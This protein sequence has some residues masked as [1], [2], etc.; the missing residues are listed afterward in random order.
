MKTSVISVLLKSNKDPTQPSSYCPLSLINTHVK[1][2]TKAIAIRLETVIATLIHP[3]QTGHI[4]KRHDS[5]N[6]QRSFNV[7]N[8]ALQTPT[9]TIIVSLDAEKAFDLI[10]H[11]T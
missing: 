4:K 9:K 1:I 11:I 5:D 6:L 8:L 10:T 3:D 2:I 7:I